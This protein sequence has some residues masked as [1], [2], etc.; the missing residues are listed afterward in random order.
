MKGRTKRSRAGANGRPKKRGR[1]VDNRRFAQNVTLGI[2]V[3]GLLLAL[4]V[5]ANRWS[6]REPLRS[7]AVVGT[8]VLDSAEV[9]GQ[10]AI[11]ERTSLSGIDL[12][13]LERRLA[14]HP[15]IRSGMI[16]RDAEG[17]VVEIEERS[18]VAVTIMDGRAV[19]L[20][21]RGTPLPFRFGVATPDVPLLEGISD[22]GEIDSTALAETI[23]VVRMIRE[24]GSFL[25]RQT[26]T[27]ARDPK[28]EYSLRL[29]DGDVF[30]RLGELG[31]IRQR[32]PKLELFLDQVLLEQ[33]AT[34]FASIDLRWQ[35]QVVVRYRE[36]REV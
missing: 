2:V 34:R 5:M 19:Y 36:G 3:V 10:L 16:W 26:S 22:R 9:A 31:A 7:I 30:V 14:A 33:G 27:I 32:L 4:V 20:D 13:E 12:G 21:D 28:G 23:E 17:L 8:L 6:D 35:G 25:A 1:R 24:G 11:P 15:F 29:V 18:P